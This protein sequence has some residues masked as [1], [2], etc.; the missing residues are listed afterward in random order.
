MV[1]DALPGEMPFRLTVIP[2]YIMFSALFAAG[3]MQA[4]CSLFGTR[5]MG[6]AVSDWWA[7]A[8]KQPWLK[9]LQWHM[10]LWF[11]AMSWASSTHT[12]GLL[13]RWCRGFS[14]TF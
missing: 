10:C 2:P 7:T 6:D 3:N 14:N 9:E 12:W 13:A 5:G 8:K 1:V 4:T 11:V